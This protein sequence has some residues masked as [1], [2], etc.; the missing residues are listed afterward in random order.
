MNKNKRTKIFAIENEKIMSKWD[1]DENEKN[2]LRPENITQGSHIKV[3]FKCPDC[4]EKWISEVRYGDRYNGCPNCSKIIAKKNW[5]KAQLNKKEILFIT[6]PE[7]EKEWDYEKNNKIGLDPQLLFSGSN[8]EAYWICHKGHSYK[9]YISNRALKKT[10]CTYCSGQLVLPNFNDLAT[11]NPELL[12]EWDY[13][14]NKKIGL[15]PNNIMRGSHKEAYWICPIG[16]EYKRDIHSRSAGKGCIICSKESQTSFP[17]QAIYFYLSK[18]FDDVKNRYGKPEIDIYIP[19]L[20]F[21]IEYD[22]LYSHRNKNNNDKKKD[23]IIKSK[24]IRL[25]RVKEILN[26][27]ENTKDVI[28]CKANSNNTFLNDV[29]LKIVEKINQEYFLDINIVPDIINDRIKIEEQ[30]IK[31]KK[32]NSIIS[33]N[34]ELEK[35]WDYEKNGTI[36][37]EYISYG[38]S[39]KFFWICS[40]NHSYQQS[41]KNRHLGKGCPICVGLRFVPGVN[42]LQTKYPEI[43]KYWDYKLNKTK[44]TEIKYTNL[45]DFYWKC[46]KGHSYTA[47]IQMMITYNGCIVCN[48]CTMKLIKGYNDLATVFPELIE[49][50]DYKNNE[51]TPDNYLA[52]SNKVVHWICKKCGYNWESKIFKRTNC[53]NCKKKS[54]I[55]NVYLIEN[56]EMIYTFNNIFDLCNKLNINYKKQHGNITSICKRNQKTLMNKYIL[57]YNEDDEFKM[58]KIIERKE[59][60]K[61]YLNKK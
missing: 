46:D 35:E 55:I 32:E 50:W 30:Y 27:I 51:N 29:I 4:G 12:K 54:T 43:L 33:M 15:E 17:E 60:I 45:N 28:F 36:R 59:K 38:S 23:E 7:L 13:A 37:P 49:E 10:G 16:H 25:L 48:K 41:P 44:P 11:T 61:G 56:G 8:K 24:G 20:R 40:N 31:S 39:K 21:G 19:Q 14:K 6:N 18:I 5:T 22:G 47:K 3:N 34:P 2:N 9:A 1:F 57:R 53:P 52:K 26:E 58:L 42:D